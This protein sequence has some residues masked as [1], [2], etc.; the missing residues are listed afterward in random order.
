VDIVVIKPLMLT[1]P[2][3]TSCPVA[4]AASSKLSVQT[5]LTLQTMLTLLI[6]LTLLNSDHVQDELAVASEPNSP[7]WTILNI[8]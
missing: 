5:L 2:D 7:L 3:D 4:P 8:D 1:D 6:L